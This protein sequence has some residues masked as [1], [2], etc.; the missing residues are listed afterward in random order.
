VLEWTY[1]I[2][3]AR[4]LTAQPDVQYTIEPGGTGNIPNALVMGFQLAVTF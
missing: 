3:L 4:S 1:V 2:Q